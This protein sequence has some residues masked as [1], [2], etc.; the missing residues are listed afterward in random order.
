LTSGHKRKSKEAPIYI[1]FQLK[2]EVVI[3]GNLG[4]LGCWVV[5]KRI[6]VNTR[7]GSRMENGGMGVGQ[8]GSL[9]N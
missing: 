1:F 4:Y 3:G 5:Q 6:V 9:K 7:V 2:F 8:K